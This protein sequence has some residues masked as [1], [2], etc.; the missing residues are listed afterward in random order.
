MIFRRSSFD[1]AYSRLTHQERQRVNLAVD[2]LEKSFGH[3]HEHGGL[4]IRSIGHFFECRAGLQ[5]RVLFVVT[6]GDLIL[7]TVGSHD[8][9]RAYIKAN[10]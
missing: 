1:R 7:V 4:G 2:R 9:I 3:P 5:I 10:S 8:A 6:G